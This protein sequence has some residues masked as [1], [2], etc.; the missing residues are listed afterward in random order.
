MNERERAINTERGEGDTMETRR[1]SRSIFCDRLFL[2]L[3]LSFGSVLAEQE[4]RNFH[5]SLIADGKRFSN[6]HC[7]LFVFLGLK[8]IDRVH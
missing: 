3:I 6:V 2:R 7:Q 8:A 1:R 5:E 4:R